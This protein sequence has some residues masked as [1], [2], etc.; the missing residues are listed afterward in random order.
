MDVSQDAT[1]SQTLRTLDF[2][3]Q[4]TELF[5]Q[6]TKDRIRV[7]LH[8]YGAKTIKPVLFD[9]IS[10]RISPFAD[11]EIDSSLVGV[12]KNIDDSGRPSGKNLLV[13]FINKKLIQS[14]SGADNIKR[15][16]TNLKNKGYHVVVIATTQH[17]DENEA[18]DVMP[19][20]VII[21]PGLAKKLP[22]IVVVIERIIGDV[23]FGECLFQILIKKFEVMTEH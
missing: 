12:L 2:M 13:V 9:E 20:V 23:L 4:I 8:G 14:Q 21:N 18:R 7:D 3:S 15:Y 22:D 6:K 16:I 1:H 11:G 17:F 10:K 19:G 5:D